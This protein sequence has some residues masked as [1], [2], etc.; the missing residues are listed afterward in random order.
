MWTEY[1]HFVHFCFFFFFF[2][3]FYF[4]FFFF[5]FFFIFSPGMQG[6][7]PDKTCLNRSE[8]KCTISNIMLISILQEF[9]RKQRSNIFFFTYLKSEASEKNIAILP[10][11]SHLKSAISDIQ[12]WCLQGAMEM[13]ACPKSTTYLT[14]VYKMAYNRCVRVYRSSLVFGLGVGRSP[15]HSVLTAMNYAIQCISVSRY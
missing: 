14:G 13:E 3:F 7:E 9:P 8:T 11:L 15:L 5:F 12:I 6:R 1:K 2:F 4:F 10:N